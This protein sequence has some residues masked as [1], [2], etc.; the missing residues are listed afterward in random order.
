MRGKIA[1]EEHWSIPETM[2]DS[3]RLVGTSEGWGD[4]R[5][6][7]LDIYDERLSQM[8]VNGIELSILSL[9]A[10]AIQAILDPKEAI[11]TAKIA[12]DT[13]AE[14][15]AKR[16]DRFRAFAALP[17]QDADA[18]AA[19]LT[20]CVKELGFVGALVN[21][22]TQCEVEDSV[23]YFDIPEYRS[24]WRT[25]AELDVPFYLHP[26]TQ[27]MSRRQPYDGH[28]WLVSA[29]WGFARETS[30]H[31][32][33]LMGSG[34]FDEH[35]DLR[36]I[37][38]HL[39]ERIPYDISRLD[40]RLRRNPVGYSCKRKMGDYFRKNFYVTTSGHFNDPPFHCAIGELGIEHIMFSVDYPFEEM[41]E[42][43]SWFDATNLNETERHKIGRQNAVELFNLDLS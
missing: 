5:H 40:H 31:A 26:R 13:L 11:T 33:R 29:A 10:P 27:I 18:A 37:L 8:D 2:A 30:I 24:F 7:L 15:T 6:R 12:N 25:V 39:G 1:L 32:L 36:I 14:I 43:A 9:N 19:E 28:P 16:P 41:T 4:L 17:M 3:E 22:F 38:G 35:P 20:R 34:L 21:G 23:I 42:A